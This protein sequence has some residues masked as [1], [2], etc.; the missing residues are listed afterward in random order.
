MLYLLNFTEHA[1][2]GYRKKRLMHFETGT[3][4]SQHNRRSQIARM[5]VDDGII[6]YFIM[7]NQN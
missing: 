3:K 4:K 1:H 5:D 6:R 2:T 7:M